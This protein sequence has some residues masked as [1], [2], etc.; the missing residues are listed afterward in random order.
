MNI[1][2]EKWIVHNSGIDNKLKQ[3]AG[4]RGTVSLGKSRN[5]N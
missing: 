1:L 2:P 3:L 4:N 5:V